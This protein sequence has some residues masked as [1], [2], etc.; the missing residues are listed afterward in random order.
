[1]IEISHERARDLAQ[2][3]LDGVLSES[4]AL[5]LHSHLEVCRTCRAYANGLRRL[6]H[7]IQHGLRAHRARMVGRERISLDALESRLK[8]KGAQ[9]RRVRRTVLMGSG[10]VLALVALFILQIALIPDEGAHAT[11]AAT[12]RFQAQFDGLVVY[13]SGLE[14]AREVHV[15]RAG[16]KPRNLSHY[17]GGDGSDESAP[18]WSPDGKWIA[19]LSNRTGKLEI[20]TMDA[21]GENL[22][23]V[24]DEPEVEWKA[25]LSWSADGARLAAAGVL[26]GGKIP[27]LYV[28]PVDGG[29]VYSVS[30]S[31]GA[32]DPRW[33]TAGDW[34]AFHSS[35][36]DS[37]VES[38]M[39]VDVVSK[40]FQSM[41]SSRPVSALDANEMQSF[42]A[43]DWSPRGEGLFSIQQG[44]FTRS[45]DEVNPARNATAQVNFS[46]SF[47]DAV[48]LYNRQ[49]VVE[50]SLED[51]PVDVSGS[52]Q[53]QMMAYLRGAPD[54]DCWRLHVAWQESDA[55]G[56]Q[57]IPVQVCLPVH[58]NDQA[59]TPDGGWLVFTARPE[60]GLLRMTRSD[61]ALYALD[62]RKI[63]DFQ[64]RA[65]LARLTEP[66]ELAAN[67]QV[68]PQGAPLDVQ[69]RA[70]APLPAL[71][72]P[73]SQLPPADLGKL[74][75]ESQL[76]PGQLTLLNPDGSGH[77]ALTYPGGRN[78][79]PTQL[80]RRRQVAYLTNQ[81]SAGPMLSFRAMVVDMDGAN[82]HELLDQPV[83]PL[84]WADWSPDGKWL[85][86]TYMN[87][88]V[89]SSQI[90]PGLI[91]YS[92]DGKQER[93]YF[94]PQDNAGFVQSV[95]WRPAWTPQYGVFQSVEERRSVL[96]IQLQRGNGEVVFYL[97][98]PSL[99]ED[100][101]AALQVIAT[102]PE[103][104]GPGIS[105]SVW[106]PDGMQVGYF[107]LGGPQVCRIRMEN[108]SAAPDCLPVKLENTHNTL[109][110]RQLAW[111]PD[112]S[113]MVLAYQKDLTHSG[114]TM[115]MLDFDRRSQQTLLTLPRDIYMFTVSPIHDHPLDDGPWVMYSDESGIYALDVKAA[116][117]GEAGP[118]RISDDT[119]TMLGWE[120]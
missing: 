27:R 85:A 110:L 69:P 93:E 48:G 119:S 63:R 79:F 115:L 95:H 26:M 81:D 70:A 68:Q 22:V 91:L 20:Y 44:P 59:W 6:E 71:P 109:L 12:R 114:T 64:H 84:S 105:S 5:G 117:A 103:S 67:P 108:L 49:W 11:D 34:V 58:F 39:L 15:L 47:E 42:A 37:G 23:Q 2:A 54:G 30:Y 106:S 24:T 90:Y 55:E 32:S 120:K 102:F 16:Q 19:F 76:Q 65:E 62:A 78:I 36:S 41:A 74:V 96:L 87:N 88:L 50:G 28:V 18:V 98:D 51:G 43:F 113:Q 82:R 1:M 97:L 3:A 83:G 101:P 8:R 72:G 77:Q 40:Q 86:A 14:G 13:E 73:P 38:L 57:D 116:L 25:P 31:Q 7:D 104:Q 66:S 29:Q 33:S 4:E 56:L 35:V 53:R 9:S 21:E 107:F 89:L 75:Y 10:L 61:T 60:M 118:A 80:A 17:S 94:L 100:S 46:V 52:P 112:S 45:L 92:L 111:L 99:P